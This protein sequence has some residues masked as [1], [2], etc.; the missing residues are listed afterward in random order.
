[1][2]KSVLTETNGMIA[3]V[4]LNAPERLNAL[5]KDSW[6]GLGEAIKQLS[7]DDNLRCIFL[8]QPLFSR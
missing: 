6:L 5:N 7:A 8:S 4:T 2:N 3:T 1:M